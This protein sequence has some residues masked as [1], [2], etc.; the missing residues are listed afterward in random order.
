MRFIVLTLFPEMFEPL[1]HSIVGR[2]MD[3]GLLE[4]SL[5]NIRDFSTDKHRRVDDAPYGGGAGMVMC[6]QPVF[7]AGNF[8]KSLCKTPAPFIYL[9]PKGK[10]LT[11]AKAQEL[12]QNQDVILLCGHYE[13]ID[14]RVLDLLVTEE[15]SLGDFVLTGGE[16][17]AMTVIDAAS[18]L[19]P[20]VL[21]KEESHQEESFSQ[22]LLEHPH[23]TRP[24][25]FMG[26]S[27]PPVLLSGNHA[28]IAAW[29]LEQSLEITKR[30]RPEL[31]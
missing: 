15:L 31:L 21:G 14:Q 3:K 5:I 30:L 6:A 19:V 16:L 27:V 26:L 4:L 12:S 28:Q 25:E 10:T 20:G 22:G 9:S 7:D 29:R 17:A 18:R 23:Y 8:A 11:Q 1:R 13:G 24:A 2:A